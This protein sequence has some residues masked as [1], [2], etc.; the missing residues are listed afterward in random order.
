MCIRDSLGPQGPD[1]PV[2]VGGWHPDGEDVP[3]AFGLGADPGQAEPV[4][5][6]LE[7]FAEEAGVGR[8]LVRDPVEFFDLFA[9]DGRQDIGEQVA[10]ARPLP[11]VAGGLA[12]QEG[13]PV[14]ALLADDLGPFGQGRVAGGQRS[15]LA[16]GQVLGLVETEAGGVLDGPD[17]P[18]PVAGAQG[19][20]GVGD[21]GQS[22]GPAQ[23]QELVQAQGWP[24]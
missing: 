5:Q 14:G 15:P 18:A 12:T 2:A 22:V 24:A 10:G 13:R 8:P 16:A 6:R 19:V 21:D 3:A 1:E 7:P 17:R 20:G 9:Q 23:G 4:G 11:G